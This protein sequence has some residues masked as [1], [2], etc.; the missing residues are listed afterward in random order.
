M[1]PLVDYDRPEAV[2][3]PKVGPDPAVFVR[4]TYA[5]ALLRIIASHGQRMFA[6]DGH[7]GEI[8]VTMSGR[9]FYRSPVPRTGVIPLSSTGLDYR[10]GVPD[11]MPKS[12]SRFLGQLQA[13]VMHGK[14]LTRESILPPVDYE[15]TAWGRRAWGYT[16]A[17]REDVF[18]AMRNLPILERAQ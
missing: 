3:P 8:G 1:M 7:A 2:K 4:L 10:R 18:E 16:D 11:A 9:T 5:N 17:D 12:A 15:T 6:C 14:R 13:Y